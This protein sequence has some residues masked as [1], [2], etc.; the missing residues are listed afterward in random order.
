MALNKTLSHTAI[1]TI[2]TVIGNVTSLVMLPINT[3]YLSPADYGSVELLSIVLD[4]T[5]IVFGLRVDQGL[6]RYYHAYE[7][8]E[9]RNAVVST[10]L[11]LT[12]L[13]NAVGALFIATFSPALAAHVLHD[14]TLWHYFAIY[15]LCLLAPA[16]VNV[17]YSYARLIGRPGLFLTMSL[18]KLFMQVA[19]NILFVVVFELRALGVIISTVTTQLLLGTIFTGMTLGNV[20]WRFDKEIAVRLIK[21]GV[22]IVLSGIASFYV[23]FGDRYFLNKYWGLAA[24]GLYSLATKFGFTFYTIVYEPFRKAWDGHKYE[25]LKEA[26]P[27]R[28]YQRTFSLITKALILGGLGICLFIEDFLR[29]FVGPEF[30]GAHAVVPIIIA[31]FVA[32][33][34]ID[35]CSFGLLLKEKTKY[36]S[37]GSF[38]AAAVMT[39]G[40]F[41]LIPKFGVHGAAFTTLA[42]AVTEMSWT[43]LTAKR[44]YDMQLEWNRFAATA[45][46]CVAAFL[47]SLPLESATWISFACRVALFFAAFAAVLLSPATRADERKVAFELSGKIISRLRPRM[48]AQ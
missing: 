38:L 24:V 3:R 39:I 17:P 33:P 21:F 4:I 36:L 32:R 46:I 10:V 8:I 43:Y 35:F 1:Y 22:P 12:L 45:A 27:I 25:A 11:F 34:L 23:V 41:T 37:Q 47:L 6:F 18:V 9:K 5:L 28:I 14:S 26:S 20:G 16:L 44:F 42:G 30:Q 40:Y 31:A 7:E 13:L 15:S 2:G 48:T 19:L 29:I